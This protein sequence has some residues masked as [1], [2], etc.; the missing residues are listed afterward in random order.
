MTLH[1]QKLSVGSTGI[2]SLADWQTRLAAR[3]G[4]E[5]R[6]ALPDH[7]TRMFPKRAEELLDGG[8]IYWVIKGLILCRSQ[9]VGLEETTK[10]GHKACR[11]VMRP[12]LI[13]VLPTPRRAFQGWRYLAAADAP[14]D[15]TM[16]SELDD[17]PPALLRKLVEIG[18]R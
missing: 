2:D 10:N 5:G 16:G 17:L 13:P 7:V 14:K 3:R 18:V 15:M 4:R 12:G 1:L 6:A 11:I 8:S 9:I